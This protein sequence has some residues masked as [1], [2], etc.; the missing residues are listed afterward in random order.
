MRCE[1]AGSTLLELLEG[2]LPPGRRAEIVGHLEVCA[3]CGNELSAYES[4]LALVRADPVPEPSPRLWEEFLPS[5]KRRIE[6]AASEAPREPASWLSG[7][8]SWRVFP[9]P[10]IAGVAVAAISIL[11]VIRLPGLLSVRTELQKTPAPAEQLA[12]GESGARG[13]SGVVPTEAARREIGD[14]VIVAGEAVEDVLMLAAAIQRLPWV[15]EITDRVETAWVWR[16]E[17]DPRDWL[18]SLSEEEQQI[19][20]DHLRGFRW[21]PS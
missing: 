5:L 13:S 7:L 3:A 21:S 9:R 1:E 14:P 19:L 2:E 20:I 10:L 11:I 8:R 16:P 17:S 18:A 6:Q 4:L 15:D 12:G